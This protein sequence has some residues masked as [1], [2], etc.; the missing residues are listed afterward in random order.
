MQ[1]SHGHIKRRLMPAVSGYSGINRQDIRVKK[2]SVMYL[3]L[4]PYCTSQTVA[5][6]WRRYD[7]LNKQKV[8]PTTNL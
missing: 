7:Y 4:R 5:S 2:A 3:P 1:V 8:V 6:L